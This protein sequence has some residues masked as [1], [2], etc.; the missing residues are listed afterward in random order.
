MKSEEP[1]SD[2]SK[3]PKVPK[4]DEEPVES[5]TIKVEKPVEKLPVEKSA[6]KVEKSTVSQPDVSLELIEEAHPDVGNVFISSAIHVPEDLNTSLK[7]C[8]EK[9][10]LFSIEGKAIVL[11]TFIH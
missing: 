8:E 2:K 11:Y 1:S 6:E 5:T 3:T 7:M 10:E 9:D 4:T